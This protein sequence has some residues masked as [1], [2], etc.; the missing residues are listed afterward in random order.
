MWPDE[1]RDHYDAL[2]KSKYAGYHFVF[3]M[4]SLFFVFLLQWR[5]DWQKVRKQLYKENVW[6][7]LPSDSLMH[8]YMDIQ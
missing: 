5:H 4:E 8:V 3:V 1:R 2:Y 7:M 6:S